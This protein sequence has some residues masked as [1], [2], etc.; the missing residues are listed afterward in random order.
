MEKKYKNFCYVDT[1]Y[2]LFIFLLLKG[3]KN[4]YYFF[5]KDMYLKLKNISIKDKL[6]LLEEPKKNKKSII[7]FWWNLY[8]YY[9]L[10]DKVCKK[11]GIKKIYLQDHIPIAQYFLNNY[12][13]FLL[14]DGEVN[15]N[16]F[17]LKNIDTKVKMAK[18]KYR[19]L[20]KIKKKYPIFG[21]SDKISKIYLTGIKEIPMIIKDKVE[22]VKLEEKWEKLE[23]KE[24]KN[25]LQ[26]FNIDV[27]VWSSIKWKEKVLL[28]P[29]PL[30]E[31]KILLEEEKIELYKKITSDILEENLVIKPHPREKTMY[32][33]IFSKSIVL[34]QNFPLEI[35]ILLNIRVKEVRT[36]FST[37]AYNFIGKTKVKISGTEVSYKLIKKFGIIEKKEF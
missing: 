12:D 13:C 15:Y 22:I 16:L 35:L 28:I 36:L 34:N 27:K 31:D 24:K 26:I 37:A 5:R 30:S 23:L 32:R 33:K 1:V 4:N 21:I 18:L 17:V 25:I 9:N 14:E 10:L 3:T 7:K 20:K 11:L 29:Q 8:K 2:S 6:L 19:I